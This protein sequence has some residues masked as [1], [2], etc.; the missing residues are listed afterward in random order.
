MKQ[1]DEYINK[2]FIIDPDIKV[3]KKHQ[4]FQD[5][6]SRDV[7]CCRFKECR[8]DSC[9]KSDVNTPEGDNDF[10]RIVKIDDEVQQEHQVSDELDKNKDQVSPL[11]IDGVK[12]ELEELE[13]DLK[14]V[15]SKF[16]E[17]YVLSK[18]SSQRVGC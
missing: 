17:E 9:N 7:G 6:L 2:D 11:T 15:M 14:Y 8:N 12:V 13:N 3:K 10:S 18:E 4:L 16:S 5:I 1:D